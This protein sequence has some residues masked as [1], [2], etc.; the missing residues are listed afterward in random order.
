M[1]RFEKVL[2]TV[3]LVVTTTGVV[4]AQHD[5]HHDAAGI[6]ACGS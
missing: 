4:R 2:L 1:V 5:G 3:G 6:Q